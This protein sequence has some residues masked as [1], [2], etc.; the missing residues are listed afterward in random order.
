MHKER[1]NMSTVAQ[2]PRRTSGVGSGGNV[3][4]TVRAARARVG[5]SCGWR[6]LSVG[7]RNALSTR[8]GVRVGASSAELAGWPVVGGR[9]RSQRTATQ[10]ANQLVVVHLGHSPVQCSWLAREQSNRNI[11]CRRNKETYDVLKV[12]PLLLRLAVDR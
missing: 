5:G 2:E 8:C 4:T 1:Q 11:M 6:G 9:R 3:R 10:S 7:A 12:T